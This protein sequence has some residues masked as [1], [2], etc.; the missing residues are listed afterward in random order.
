MRV[1]TKPPHITFLNSHH[2]KP[3]ESTT[4]NELNDTYPS[5][6]LGI[7]E[8]LEVFFIISWIQLLDSQVCELVSF[9]R[10]WFR[11]GESVD[12]RVKVVEE[13]GD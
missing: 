12:P 2:H 1:Q 13:G 6:N 4:V 8:A 11:G 7:G 10:R 9:R 5:V 3:F